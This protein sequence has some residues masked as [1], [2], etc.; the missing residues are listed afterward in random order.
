[1]VIKIVKYLKIINIF[2]DN[3]TRKLGHNIINLKLI[4]FKQIFSKER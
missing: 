1:M 3:F 2:I 4:S